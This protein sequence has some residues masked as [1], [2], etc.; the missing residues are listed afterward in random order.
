[1]PS[2]P[3]DKAVMAVSRGRIYDAIALAAQA[4]ERAGGRIFALDQ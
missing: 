1:M 2:R 3:D 4:E